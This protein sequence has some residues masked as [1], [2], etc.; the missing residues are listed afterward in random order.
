[1][2]RLLHTADLHLAE[3]RP[4][5]WEALEVLV[6][7]AGEREVDLVVVAG[8]LLDREGD[9]ALLRPRVRERLDRF[10]APVLLVPGNHDLRAYREGQDW[11]SDVRVLAGRPVEAVRAAGVRVIGVP[12]PE[13]E[14]AFARVR[15][16]VEESVV[17]DAP[18][19]LLAHGTLVDAADTRIQE[20]SQADEPGRYFPIRTSDLEALPVA[21]A[22]LGHYHRFDLRRLGGTTVAYAGSPTP[23]GAHALGP[24]RAV[25][26]RISRDDA[27]AEAVRLPV[28]Y[29]E[30]L[31]R[32]LPPFREAEELARLA[33][34]LREGSDPACRLEVTLDGILAGMDEEGLRREAERL[35]ERLRSAYASVTVETRAVGLDRARADLFREFQERLEER[36]RAEEE[37][38]SPLPSDLRQRVLD[39][40]ARAL[41]G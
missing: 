41:R 4:E 38:G 37:S 5:R 16:R 28:A 12:F 1:M 25:V 6:E 2:T 27:E 33:D 32:W 10:P 29:R 18:N 13:E 35:E 9:H 20:E 15:G 17:D 24:R 3:D 30:R 31:L 14:I 34:E 36:A 39:L 21:Y 26:V 8:D 23:I 11:G 19:V 40:G 22:A 7:L